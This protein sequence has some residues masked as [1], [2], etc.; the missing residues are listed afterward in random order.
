MTDEEYMRLAFA[1]ARR[2][3]E[4]GNTP[5]GAILVDPDGEIVFE[6]ENN[7]ISDSDCT[8]H[9]ETNLVRDACRHLGVGALGGHTLFTSAEPCCMCSAA[10][11]WA[12]L[13]RMVFGLSSARL[14]EVRG[15]GPPM[16]DLNSREVISRSRAEMKI[17]GPVLEDEAVAL[18]A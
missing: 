15:G 6:A 16:L 4:N 5:F 14:T 13:G 8:G 12:G 10:M 18:F 7:V 17:D 9:A 11:I 1:V 3:E 2:A